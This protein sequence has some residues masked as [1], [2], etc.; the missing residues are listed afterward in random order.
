MVESTNIISGNYRNSNQW[1]GVATILKWA[2][3]Q[4]FDLDHYLDEVVENVTKAAYRH[5]FGG[6]GNILKVSYP[7]IYKKVYGIVRYE[8]SKALTR[9]ERYNA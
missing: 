9:A 8:T 7:K 3:A 4:T 6:S 2:T 5:I 1:T